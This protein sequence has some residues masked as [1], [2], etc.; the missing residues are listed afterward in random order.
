MI[1]KDL[2]NYHSIEKVEHSM[3]IAS[4]YNK[5]VPDQNMEI[6]TKFYENIVQVI[7]YLY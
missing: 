6:T 4:S 5:T 2:K 7:F 3:L 1:E